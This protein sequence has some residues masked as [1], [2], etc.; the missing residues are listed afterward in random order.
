MD[1]A[2][3]GREADMPHILLKRAASG[4]AKQDLFNSR[5][6]DVRWLALSAEVSG[7]VIRE[8]G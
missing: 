7:E 1:G 8:N 2:T 3:I 5:D 4:E 6:D